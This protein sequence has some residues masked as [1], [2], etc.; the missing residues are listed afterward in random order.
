MLQMCWVVLF[1]F[2]LIMTQLQ[3]IGP[4]KYYTYIP[5]MPQRIVTKLESCQSIQTQ[6]DKNMRCAYS[7]SFLNL[8]TNPYGR[9]EWLAKK[10]DD[11]QIVDNILP[12]NGQD[13]VTAIKAHTNVTTAIVEV[14]FETTL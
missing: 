3:H 11:M 7:G 9:V 12:R 2:L 10:H 13:N 1:A 6:T 5:C 14:F 4:Y 8:N